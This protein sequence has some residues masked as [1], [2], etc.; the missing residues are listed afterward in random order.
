MSGV[1]S[2]WLSA[3]SRRGPATLVAMVAAAAVAVSLA[4]PAGAKPAREKPAAPTAPVPEGSRDVGADEE[5]SRPDVVSARVSARATGRRVEV[6]GLR[7]EFSTTWVNPDGTFTTDAHAGQQRF[8][9]ADGAWREVDLDLTRDTDGAVVA[10]GHPLGL[11]LPGKAAAAG[12]EVVAVGHGRGKGRDGKPVER[13]VALGWDKKLPAPVLDGARAT[14]PDVQPEVDLVVEARRS[15]FEQFFVVKDRAAVP[16]SG[17]VSWAF[18]V[19]TKGLTVTADDDGG[20][21]FTDAA[22]KVVSRIPPALAWDAVVDERSGD[23][24]NVAPVA[25][26][27]ATKGEQDDDH[28]QPG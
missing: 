24:V 17:P 25:L 8:R 15:G 21:S 13:T 9:D 5:L 20:I 10:K 4:G 22:G 14:Y 6:E 19:K 1:G 26:A 18:T 16:A 2:W 28:D 12:A 7:D 27:A 23:P 11:R 3:G